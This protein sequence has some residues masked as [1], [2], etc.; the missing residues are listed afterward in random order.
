MKD[1]ICKKGPFLSDYSILWPKY[2]R[3]RTLAPSKHCNGLSLQD[4]LIAL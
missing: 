2:S 4:F 1:N 3:S